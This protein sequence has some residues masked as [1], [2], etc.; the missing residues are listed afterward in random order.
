MEQSE[1]LKHLIRCFESLGIPYLLTGSIAS[2]AYGEPR[3]T[4]DIDIVA[5]IKT[6]H[7]KGLKDCFP[8]QEFYLSEDA[9]KEAVNRQH[10]FNIIHPAT[11]LKIDII[12]RKQDAFDDSRFKRIKR[13]ITTEN[14]EA[15]FAAPEDVI[16]KK[17]AFYKEG[18]SEKHLRDITG[19]LKISGDIIDYDYI[20]KWAEKLG[21]K[22]IWDAVLKR[23]KH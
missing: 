10:Q 4:N 15:N 9:I 20:S 2:M 21:I 17:M 11:G 16:I 18:G 8:E 1:L 14:I 23:I 5:D 6:E 22:D 12:I 13:L 19:M 3:F 7:I